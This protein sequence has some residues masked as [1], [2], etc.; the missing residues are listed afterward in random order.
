LALIHKINKQFTL[1]NDDELGQAWSVAT[2]LTLI[3]STRARAERTSHSSQPSSAS[4]TTP[5]LLTLALEPSGEGAYVEALREWIERVSPRTS[6]R[7][8]LQ[9]VR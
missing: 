5:A 8:A 6:T 3:S 7:P 2:S 4:S 1:R 9:L